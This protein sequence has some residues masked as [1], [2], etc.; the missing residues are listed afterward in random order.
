MMMP[1]ML[2][3][4]SSSAAPEGAPVDAKSSMSGDAA[5]TGEIV[6][7]GSRIARRDFVSDSPIVTQ[8]ANQ[9]KN[10]GVVS[11]ET[12]L[13]RLP[14]FVPGQGAYTVAQGG[15]ATLNLRGLGEQRNLVLLDGRRLPP[16][17]ALGV[18]NVNIIPQDILAG[19]ETISGGASATY[20]SDA[21]SG[22]V[23]FKTKSEYKGIQL[24]LQKGLSSRG[25]VPQTNAALMAGTTSGDGNT[26][27]MISLGY[28]DRASLYG[29]DRRFYD[30]SA[31]SSTIFGGTYVP[32]GNNL[33]SQAAVRGVFAKYGITGG[34]TTTTPFG[35]NNN[36][37]IFAQ[38]GAANY[39]SVGSPYMFILNDSVSSS[40][41]MQT[42]DAS[43]ETR[44]SM[45][46]K[47]DH[48]LNDA[49]KIYAQGLFV[50]DDVKTDA[51]WIPSLLISPTIP[52]TNPYIPADLAT[53][54]ASRPNPTAPF[55]YSRR[56]DNMPKRLIDDRS[57]TYQLLIGTGGDLGT[58]DLT[59]DIYGSTGETRLIEEFRNAIL[60]SRLQNL[61]SAPDGG[62][63]ICAGGFNPFGIAGG[64]TISQACINYLSTTTHA[65][66]SVKQSVVEAQVQG[67]LFRFNGNPVKFALSAN[68]RKDSYRF[69]PD[70]SIAARD[71]A[72]AIVAP[73]AGGSRHVKEVAA[74]LSAPLM[75]D[76]PFAERL[77]VDLGYR[78]SDYAISG[79]TSTYK[80]S[81]IWKPVSALMFRGGYEHAIRA[82]G[83]AELFAAANGGLVQF[84]TPPNAGD[85]CDS[86]SVARTGAA[87]AQLSQLCVNTGVPTGIVNSF[88]YT[89]NAIISVSS[90]STALKPETADT[91]T[92]G[93][94]LHP[95]SASSALLRNLSLSADYYNIGLKNA[96]S[97][98][99]G[100]TI[101]NKCY[102]LDGSN[103]AYS[104]SSYYCQ[105]IHRDGGGNIT[106]VNTPYL[107]LGGVRTSG[108]DFQLDWA[109]G[110]GD[111]GLDD[112]YGR[113]ALNTTVSWLQHYKISQLPGNPFLDYRKTIDATPVTGLLLPRWRMQSILTYTLKPMEIG[114]TWQHIPG[115]KDVSSVTRPTNPSPGVGTYDKFDLRVSF[116]V[117]RNFDFSMLVNNLTDRKPLIVAGQPGVTSPGVY[118]IFGRSF[119]M[120]LRAKL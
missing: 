59:W 30:R 87:A 110:F 37:T 116:A 17:T 103:T 1:A 65:V 95:Q 63:S 46:M 84:G 114:L 6:V 62:N 51:G 10:A 72:S 55:N 61:L 85:P 32:A 118:D 13:N 104:A 56:F 26:H 109:A 11:I 113:I 23:N 50:D 105:F 5:P 112:R 91:F 12:V 39:I 100:G 119:M 9:I 81:G 53:L 8:N 75:R 67:T 57:T 99:A 94:V 86:R 48:L 60:A 42:S 45:F 83:L 47:A 88:Q 36:G 35:F 108:I 77:E 14:Q 7:T 78:Y 27:A 38:Q 93:A 40:S 41:T 20:G 49:I 106:T 115:M 120:S 18:I 22:V 68:Y 19:I 117:T 96:I 28:Y 25:D 76:K 111:L 74:E 52:V 101:V 97:T 69:S 33:P 21:I 16:A 2:R 79:G 66:T 15:R 89:T 43:S 73:K 92:L 107:N 98:I 102:N 82:P 54:L 80:A 29:L 90:G 34:V 24:D 70:T 3:A 58:G 31:Q 71:V 64:S 44:Y 4:Q